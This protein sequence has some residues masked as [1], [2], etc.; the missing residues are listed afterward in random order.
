MDGFSS[1][2]DLAKLKEGEVK[3]RGWVY[4]QRGSDKFKFILIR[5]P[6]GVVQTII[7]KEEVNENVWETAGKLYIESSVI[8]K[9]KIK[10]DERAPGGVE[11]QVTGLEPV[12]IG[13]PYRLQKDFSTE[14]LLD[15]RHLWLRSQKMKQIMKVRHHLTIYL[16]EFFDNKGFYQVVPPIIVKNA[17]E[18]GSQL[19]EMKYFNEK[20]YLSESGQMYGESL[21]FS[22]GKIYVWAPS[23]RAEKSR[24]VR[25]LAEYWHLE[26]E[27]AWYSHED[28][29]K[30]QE[31]MLEFVVQKL[32]KEHEDLLVALGRDVDVL[33]HVKGP[34]PRITYDQMVEKLQDLDV[35]FEWGQDPG[36]DE[37]KALTADM[38]V[39]LIVEKYPAGMKAFYMRRDPKNPEYMLNDDMLAPE[40]HGEIIGG[41]ERIWELDELL[42]AMKKAK[43]DPNDPSYSWYVDLRRFGA[44]PHSG[45]GLGMERLLKW[46]LNLDHIRDAIPYPRVINRVYP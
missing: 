36:A 19:F 45:F 39:P 28:N 2:A 38:K 23:F 27:M 34:F 22:L 41:S 11:I 13:E 24:T 43:L 14:F 5:D 44:V 17:C 9:G 40:G 42:E 6:T 4:R 37:E 30:L 16:N 46:V 25:H 21:I 15:Q 18:G 35:K 29:M 33:R 26:P 8:V 31:E 10:P 20:A 1:I 3:I 32:I 12:S 7:T